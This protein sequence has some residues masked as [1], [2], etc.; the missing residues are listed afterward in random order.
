MPF[1]AE[2]S[3]ALQ[4]RLPGEQ[5]QVEIDVAASDPCLVEA[6]L[7]LEPT[8][9]DPDAGAVEL[10]MR[11]REPG[12]RRALVGQQLAAL[13]VGERG[14]REDDLP[15]VEAARVVALLLRAGA[16]ERDLEAERPVKP[17]G[18]VPPLVAGFGMRAVVARKDEALS[19]H[20]PRIGRGF[21]PG[22]KRQ[23]PKAADECPAPHRVAY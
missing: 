17:A 6:A 7:E 8:V 23:G 4:H 3:F 13:R 12:A 15:R 10:G 11:E 16:K 21:R 19:G 14:V 1:A 2:A 22:K 9:V 20:D 18:D 5:R